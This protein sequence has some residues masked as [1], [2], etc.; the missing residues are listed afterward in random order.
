MYRTLLLPRLREQVKEGQTQAKSQKI[1]T[2][3]VRLCL[4]VTSEAKSRKD[5]PRVS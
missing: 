5:H 2:F 3:A 4:L 1:N